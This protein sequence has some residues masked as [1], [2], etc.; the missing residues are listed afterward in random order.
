MVSHTG[1]LSSPAE[2]G[3]CPCSKSTWGKKL[4]TSLQIEEA[5]DKINLR[6]E[7]QQPT[8][9]GWSYHLKF[10]DAPDWVTFPK[11]TWTNVDSPKRGTNHRRNNPNQAEISEMVRFS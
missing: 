11:K 8:R 1:F 3:D 6:P 9:S 4:P 2:M 5:L 10:S 7:S